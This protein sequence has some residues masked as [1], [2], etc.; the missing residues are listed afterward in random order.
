MYSCTLLNFETATHL[1]I[2]FFVATYISLT[3]GA[4]WFK[5]LFGEKEEK[6]RAKKEKLLSPP[7]TPLPNR[8]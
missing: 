3:F 4:H 7:F 2:N 6:H 5:S 8:P 1:F